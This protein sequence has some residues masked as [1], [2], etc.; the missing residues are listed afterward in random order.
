MK[1]WKELIE[2]KLSKYDKETNV[3]G[4]Y[5]AWWVFGEVAKE[6]EID[7]AIFMAEAEN[8][9]YKRTKRG[10]NPM[11][12]NLYDLE[13]APTKLDCKKVIAQYDQDIKENPATYK[14]IEKLLEEIEGYFQKITLLKA[15]KS[16]VASLLVNYYENDSLKEVYA[17]RT[18][19]ILVSHF[20][21]GL[22][23]RYKSDD[24]LL[25][26]TTQLTILDAIRQEVV[27]GVKFFKTIISELNQDQYVRFDIDYIE[28]KRSI[29]SV[30]F[31]FLKDYV[32]NF[33]TG[34]SITKDD[35]SEEGEKTD[36]IH[37]VVRNIKN[38]ELDLKDPIYI[39]EEKGLFLSSFKIEQGD[40]VVA[41]S[42]NCGASFYFE[43]IVEEYQLTL[44]H[45][46]AKF[47]VN[48]DL[49]NPRLLVYY[50]NSKTIKKYFKAT[51]TG[52][53]QKNLSKT[54]LREL[55]ILLPTDIN[56]PNEILEEIKLYELEVSKFK[57]S[58][59]KPIDI[60]NQVIGEEFNFDW[61]AF[62]TIK[63]KRQF[64]ATLTDFSNNV[65][66][67]FGYKFHNQA[68]QFIYDFL[69][70][71]TKTRIKDFISEPIVLGKSI[72]P[73]NYD[74]EGEFYYIAMSNIK[75]WAFDPEGCKKVSESYSSAN[76]NKTVKKNDILL[77]RSGEGTI[78]KV[79]LIEDEDI[80]GIFADFTQR[81]RLKNYNHLLA[82]YYFRSDFFQNL[83][84][85]HKKGLGN[86][87]NIFPS[88]IQEFPTPD[89]TP[90]KQAE[91]VGK[92]QTE[93][94]AQSHI[95]REIEKNRAKI[96]LLIEAAIGN[97]AYA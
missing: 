24:I 38:G 93:I 30:N 10:E 8:V 75:T 55:P 12:N 67:W 97:P 27:W 73:S 96:N 15:E 79:A 52:K 83:V 49:I 90:E 45:Y 11:P 2:H 61:N 51:E 18:D 5:N 42:P 70:S 28:F 62:E 17:E 60:I 19:A 6:S 86:N 76:P 80:Q 3:F 23:S 77:A 41:F 89:W 22:L 20:K 44:S 50:L 21:S 26:N 87:T 37:L 85:T 4:F 16:Q 81:I 66:C 9:G 94:D 25:R 39:K 57:N 72:S 31:K 40:I 92:I 63:S 43:D 47:K 1:D 14:K 82:Y 84:Y 59:L 46:L 95:D 78:G 91:I 54:Y 53:T 13:Y 34:Q 33:E 68:G 56:Q 48:T 71:K 32:K 35:Y 7:Y 36:Y 58:K 29:S 64:N 69:C 74:D 65:D 88:Q